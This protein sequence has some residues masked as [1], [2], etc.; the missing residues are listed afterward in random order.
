MGLKPHS[1]DRQKENIRTLISLG[2]SVSY[3]RAMEV[4]KQLAQAV[5][6][7]WLDDGVIVHTNIKRKLFVTTV[8]DSIDEPGYEHHGTAMCLTSHL[9][10]DNIGEGLPLLN[11]FV[12]ESFSV[13]LPHRYTIAPF[14]H[15]YAGNSIIL[16]IN[17][18]LSISSTDKNDELWMAQRHWLQHAK[19]FIK[20]SDGQLQETLVT[21][22]IF[23]FHGRYSKE[24]RPQSSVGVFPTL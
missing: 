6:N 12:P 4:R 13:E 20:E 10:H 15:E 14:V 23:F 2:I 18:A 9:T 22:S 7:R 24:V 11:L 19:M 1:K 8:A 16:C 3:D 21:Y 5:C 17:G